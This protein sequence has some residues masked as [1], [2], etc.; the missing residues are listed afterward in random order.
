MLSYGLKHGLTTK[1]KDNDVFAFS[2]DNSDQINRKRLCK[3]NLNLDQRLK[4][5]LRSFSFNVP[6]IDDKSVYRDS[7]KIK[8]IKD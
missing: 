1:P 2:E 7:K 3:D 4:N 8:L 6:D 5:T